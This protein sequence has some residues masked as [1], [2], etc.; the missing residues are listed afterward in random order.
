MSMIKRIKNNSGGDKFVVTRT[1]SNGD[2][3]DL[4]VKY[5][6]QVLDDDD[7]VA[8]VVSGTLVVNDGTSDLNAVDGELWLNRFQEESSTIVYSIFPLVFSR[9]GSAQAKWMS[10]I[11][12][13]MSS[14]QTFAY[15]PFKC[16]VVGV[17]FSNKNSGV[18]VDVEIWKSA[19]GN[20]ANES[21]VYEWELSNVR[22]ARKSNISPDLTFDPGDK[23]AVYLDDEGKNPSNAVVI[24]YLQVTEDTSEESSEDFSGNF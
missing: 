17:T 11:A 8:D 16:K 3:Y 14:N 18:D 1:I 24:M 6:P 15:I 23:V 20:A 9:N 2:Y 5:W 7:F 22:V 13:V 10:N 4:D 12:D 19:E 21:M